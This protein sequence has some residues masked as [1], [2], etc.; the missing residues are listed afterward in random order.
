MKIFACIAF[1]LLFAVFFPLFRTSRGTRQTVFKGL[2]TAAALAL[3]TVGAVQSGALFG[4]LMVVGMFF[5]LIGDLVIRYN[6]LGGM[7]LF[8]A[9]HIFY[10]AALPLRQT[11]GWPSLLIF[12]LLL[13]AILCVGW[14]HFKKLAFGVLPCIAYAAVLSAMTALALPLFFAG[15]VGVVTAAGAVF[16]FVSDAT[17]A[18]MTCVP[19]KR[20]A[21]IEFFSILS[22]FL[23]Q[24]LLALSVCIPAVV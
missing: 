5:G 6:L 15:L 11:P 22:Y 21:T 4:R 18:M 1:L 10:C 3:C 13:G 14:K 8:F 16:F 12:A 7:I 23:G 24:F 17:L 2:C 9:G 20:T 19:S